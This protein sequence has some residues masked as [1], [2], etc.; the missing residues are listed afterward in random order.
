MKA[1]FYC[2]IQKDRCLCSDF[3]SYL[4]RCKRKKAELSRSGNF[5]LQIIPENGEAASPSN[6]VTAHTQWVL[7][8]E[9]LG[10][11]LCRKWFYFHKT[12]FTVS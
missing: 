4:L 6:A 8:E 1:Y 9:F 2:C 5:L 11:C 3:K 12:P 7:T 10:N